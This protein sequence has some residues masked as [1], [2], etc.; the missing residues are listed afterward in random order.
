MKK[1]KLLLNK[2]FAKHKH[3]FEYEEVRFPPGTWY[4]G[5]DIP[6]IVTC[7]TC[8]YRRQVDADMRKI[9]WSK[10]KPSS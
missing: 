4:K 10:I 1:I 2:L 7:K 5:Y 3:E 9:D 6:I 8:K